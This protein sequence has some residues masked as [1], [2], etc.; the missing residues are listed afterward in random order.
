MLRILR[1]LSRYPLTVA[2]LEAEI[3]A[4]KAG[5]TRYVVEAEDLL[6]KLAA[7]EARWRQRE[8]RKTAQDA[9]RATNGHPNGL[10]PLDRALLAR[11][12]Y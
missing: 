10:D 12:G 6:N 3:A 7:M 1:E 8:Y 5:Q 4:L 11:K 2:R 9:P